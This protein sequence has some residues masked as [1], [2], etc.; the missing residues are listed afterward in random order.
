MLFRVPDSS[1]SI[2][3]RFLTKVE[4]KSAKQTGGNQSRGVGESSEN[5]PGFLA[6]VSCEG[7]REP[8]PSSGFCSCHSAQKFCVGQIHLEEPAVP[9][10]TSR[11]ELFCFC[12]SVIAIVMDHKN[13]PQTLWHTK[14]N[15]YF[16][17]TC[18]L[19]GWSSLSW[20]WLN[21]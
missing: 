12:H 8:C 10:L 5:I 11:N 21:L 14:I 4:T 16:S 9:L 18:V 19:V 13:Q 1:D 2:I 6:P 17:L 3:L 7:V 20:A 15:I